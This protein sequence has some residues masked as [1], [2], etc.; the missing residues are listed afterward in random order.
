MEGINGLNPELLPDLPPQNTYRI[1][2]SALIL[3]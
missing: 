2:A 1:Y 3:S